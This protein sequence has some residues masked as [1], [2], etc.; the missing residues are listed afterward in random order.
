MT[1]VANGSSHLLR[2]LYAAAFHHNVN[3]L[4]GAFQ[5]AV[6]DKPADDKYFKVIALRN[7]RN[8]VKY[9]ML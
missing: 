9:R 5:D 3:I 4:A 7:V 6:P 8:N 1:I 2:Q